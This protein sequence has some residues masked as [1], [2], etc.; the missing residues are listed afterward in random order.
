MNT[1]ENMLIL[2]LP[3]KVT[4]HLHEFSRVHVKT[5]SQQSNYEIPHSACC[6][7]KEVPYSKSVAE[8]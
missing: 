1:S 7:V 8:T 4:R 6:Q 3:V 5:L 2:M